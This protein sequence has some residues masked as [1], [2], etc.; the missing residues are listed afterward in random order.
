MKD[1]E[2]INNKLYCYLNPTDLP[3]PRFYG[4]PK[5]HKLGVPMR[6]IVSYSTP[7]CKILTNEQ[8]TFLKLI[9]KMKI[10]APRV[11]SCFPTTCSY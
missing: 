3:A 1:N 7:R 11:L 8:L 9:L 2:L 10:T 4:Q 5:I 6:L